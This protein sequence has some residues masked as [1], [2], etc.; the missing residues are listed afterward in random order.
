MPAWAMR[1]SLPWPQLLIGSNGDDNQCLIPWWHNWL[2]TWH[3]MGVSV[4]AP[5]VKI[6]VASL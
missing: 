4:V 1:P 6:P 5:W 2:R 3:G